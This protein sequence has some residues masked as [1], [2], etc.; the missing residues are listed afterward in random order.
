MDDRGSKNRTVRMERMQ[1]EAE[2]ENW[3]EENLSTGRDEGKRKLASLIHLATLNSP[4]ILPPS[5]LLCPLSSFTF[6]LHPAGVDLVASD[7][8]QGSDAVYRKGL[9]GLAVSAVCKVASAVGYNM[10]CSLAT[11][12]LAAAVAHLFMGYEGLMSAACHSN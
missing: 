6:T 3:L 9:R 8:W 7:G 4:F 1:R 10:V 11:K 5:S 2:G 12:L